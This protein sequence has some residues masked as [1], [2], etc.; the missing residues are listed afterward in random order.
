MKKH[1]TPKQIDKAVQLTLNNNISIQ[2]NFIF[3]DKAETTQT[4]YETLDYWKRNNQAGII[5]GFINPYPGT[6]LYN[7]C[8]KKGII[9]DKLDFIENHVFDIINMTNKMNEEEF[10]KLKL[11]V[12]EAELKY[13]FYAH[14]LKLQKARDGTYNILVKCPHCN[15]IV[16]YKNYETLTCELLFNIMAYCRICRHRFFMVPRLYSYAIKLFLMIY[17]FMGR[18]LKFTVYN[19][20]KEIEKLKAGMKHFL[21]RF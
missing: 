13:P 8:I 20:K 11:D 4:A 16:E 15:E 3:G 5:L 2:A 12:F 6:D 19:A 9:K 7:T 10:N 17:P 1:I 18:R 21:K 14:P